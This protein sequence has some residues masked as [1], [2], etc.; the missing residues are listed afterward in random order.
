[1]LISPTLGSPALG[2]EPVYTS[3]QQIELTTGYLSG[4]ALGAGNTAVSW[5]LSSGV[6]V[7]A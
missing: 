6:T 2:R 4:A 7:F 5:F 1:M 3:F